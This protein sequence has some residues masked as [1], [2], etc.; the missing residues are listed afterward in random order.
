MLHILLIILK[1]IGIIIAVILGL[2]FVLL[3]VLLCVPIRYR[4]EGSLDRKWR[5]SRGKACV[6]WLLHL[7]RIDVAFEEQLLRWKIRIAWKTFDSEKE[8]EE[9]DEENQEDKHEKPHEED[10]TE[11]PDEVHEEV[12]S[13]KPE[14]KHE[15]SGETECEKPSE[16]SEKPRHEKAREEAC[17]ASKRE[18]KAE[19]L[20]EPSKPAES[21]ELEKNDKEKKNS[22]EDE[23]KCQTASEKTAGKKMDSARKRIEQKLGS[24]NT[25]A[26][27]ADADNEEKASLFSKIKCTIKDIC[28]K[29]KHIVGKAAD[30]TGKISDMK[31]RIIKELEDPVHQKAF[32]KVKKELGKLL[33]RWKPKELKGALHFGF[34][35]PYHTGQA[36][37]VLSMIYPFLEGNLSVNPDFE[38]RILEGDLKISGKIAIIPLVGFLWNLIWCKA[39]RQTYRD[40]RN[41]NQIK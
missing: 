5:K 7:I 15:E 22:P 13:E 31:D 16:V 29:I 38:Q 12:K 9:L 19:I 4:L 14:E 1:I 10:G 26:D 24:E 37:A 34:E 18:T 33:R 32:G 28:D 39:V 11:K 2:L 21:K 23:K 17:E 27:E 6:T 8:K 35:D 3:A 25:E 30:T 41:F 40:I 20:E 36:L